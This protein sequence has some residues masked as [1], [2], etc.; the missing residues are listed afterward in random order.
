MGADYWGKGIATA[1]LS[2]MTDYGFR[3]RHFRKLYAGVLAPNIAS[4]KVLEK[5]GYQR[6][7]VLKDEVEKGGTYFDIHQFARQRFKPR[8]AAKTYSPVPATPS[9]M[10]RIMQNVMSH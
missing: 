1:A 10:S 7:A 5:C 9:A 2:Q 3:Q 8:A 4:M 6:E